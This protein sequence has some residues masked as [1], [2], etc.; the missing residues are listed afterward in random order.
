MRGRQSI[1]GKACRFRFGDN[2]LRGLA[3]MVTLEAGPSRSFVDE[4][5][6][7]DSKI[8]RFVEQPG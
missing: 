7:L 8:R 1:K 3:R 4:Y 6:F 2:L 5:L